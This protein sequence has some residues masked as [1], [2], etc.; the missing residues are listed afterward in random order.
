MAPQDPSMGV[1]IAVI[2]IALGLFAL[3]GFIVHRALTAPA[4]R[5]V[6]VLTAAAAVLTAVGS[7]IA[8]LPVIIRA[9]NGG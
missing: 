8:V 5:P 4:L 6:A 1:V 3:I 9:L 2:V 7:V